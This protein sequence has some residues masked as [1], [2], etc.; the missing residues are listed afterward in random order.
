MNEKN[1]LKSKYKWNII[2]EILHRADIIEP[3]MVGDFSS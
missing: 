2:D 3:Y 1:T